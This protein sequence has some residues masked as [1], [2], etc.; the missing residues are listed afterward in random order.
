MAMRGPL[1]AKH[2]QPSHATPMVCII[3]QKVRRH[4]LLSAPS[5]ADQARVH[6]AGVRFREPGRRV[7]RSVSCADAHSRPINKIR[8][9][10]LM[11]MT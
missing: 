6:R 1:L 7:G 5:I 3:S 11:G 10:S 4:A 2:P 9:Q 8:Q